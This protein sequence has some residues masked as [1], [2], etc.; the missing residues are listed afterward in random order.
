MCGLLQA[1]YGKISNISRL[2][3]LTYRPSGTSP[4]RQ[5]TVHIAFHVPL[6][7]SSSLGVR[8]LASRQPAAWSTEGPLFAPDLH[9]TDTKCV[10]QLL[11]TELLLCNFDARLDTGRKASKE[12]SI[13]QSDLSHMVDIIMK[14]SGETFTAFFQM[15]IVM[16]LTVTTS[17]LSE[18]VLFWSGRVASDLK[19][20]L[21]QVQPDGKKYDS[22]IR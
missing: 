3:S 22:I 16:S 9:T 7:I 13:K 8:A 2:R 10:L 20:V 15:V 1:L 19:A 11:T 5:F 14:K 6:L 21:L 17:L 18:V 4:V 12:V